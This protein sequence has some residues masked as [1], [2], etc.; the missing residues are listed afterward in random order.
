MQM[1]NIKTNKP[2]RRME[3]GFFAF[4]HSPAL[5]AHILLIIKA[6]PNKIGQPITGPILPISAAP[7]PYTP[8]AQN[9]KTPDTIAQVYALRLFSVL[10]EDQELFLDNLKRAYPPFITKAPIKTTTHQNN[11]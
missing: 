5:N 1:A 4:F 6:K 8:K 3:K 2:I 10:K 9:Q 7:C 11:H